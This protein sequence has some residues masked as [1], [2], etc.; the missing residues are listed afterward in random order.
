MIIINAVKSKEGVLLSISDNGLGID[1]EKYGDKIF[2]MYKTFHNKED[3]K[4][5][6][7]YLVKNQIEAMGGSITVQSDVDRGTTFNVYFNEES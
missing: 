4:G 3:S 1:L 6:G 5:F 2:G 7:L